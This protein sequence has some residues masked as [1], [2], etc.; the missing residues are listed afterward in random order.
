MRKLI[1]QGDL[2]EPK[3]W[4]H[5]PIVLDHP[6]PELVSAPEL[7]LQ[8]LKYSAK[9]AQEN[10]GKKHLLFAQPKIIFLLKIIN[11]ISY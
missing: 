3:Y 2:L 4:Q 5:P 9:E 8:G 6:E 10:N 7:V 1:P 11:F